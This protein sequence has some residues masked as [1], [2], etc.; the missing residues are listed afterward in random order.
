MNKRFLK[1]KNWRIKKLLNLMVK[2]ITIS[3][4]KIFYVFG[5]F[6]K[7]MITKMIMIQLYIKKNL[8]LLKKR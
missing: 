7:I 8:N 3:I 4:L 2:F 1:K 6:G 5:E